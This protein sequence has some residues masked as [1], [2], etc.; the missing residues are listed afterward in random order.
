MNENVLAAASAYLKA[1]DNKDLA[2]I[3]GYLHPEVRFLGPMADVTGKEP[4]LASAQRMFPLMQNL[5]VR[6]IF[7]SGEQV[8]AAYD[9]ICAQPV[10]NCRTAELITFKDGLISQIEL[11]FD[12]R[13]F[14]KLTQAGDRL[15]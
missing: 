6:S 11:F 9:F 5:N 10:G 15:K 8:M 7:S 13:P 14:E 1:W 3:S 12:A 2:E 4:V